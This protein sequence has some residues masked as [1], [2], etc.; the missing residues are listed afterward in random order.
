MCS[1]DALCFFGFTPTR[2]AGFFF[3][4]ED[5]IRDTSVTGVQTWALPISRSSTSRNAS[6][7]RAPIA[8]LQGSRVCER[9]EERRVGKECRSRWPAEHETQKKTQWQ[10][11]DLI[12]LHTLTTCNQVRPGSAY[13][14]FRYS[15]E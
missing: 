15:Y 5:G 12:V 13:T 11:G 8:C 6:N 2:L 9:S 1:D 7:Q 4:G 14:L 3:R 10:L